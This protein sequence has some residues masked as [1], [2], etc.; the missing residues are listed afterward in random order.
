M[1]LDVFKEL[2]YSHSVLGKIKDYLYQVYD[3]YKRHLDVVETTGS[4]YTGARRGESDFNQTNH[5]AR[6][7]R[8]SFLC[9]DRSGRSDE[10]K[11]YLSEEREHGDEDVGTFY[12]SRKRAFPVLYL[13]A[14]DFL[15]T[16]AMSAPCESL[17]SR[18]ND[19]VTKKRNRLSSNTIKNLAV[20]KSLGVIL[21]E[22]E[23]IF[24]EEDEVVEVGE[25]EGTTDRL[26]V[27]ESVGQS[28]HDCNDDDDDLWGILGTV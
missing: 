17:F 7:M 25:G 23:T 4:N 10:I 6:S 11:A 3:E 28:D 16:P 5:E 19:V 22:A 26:Q 1:K 20:L 27:I 9:R 21:D 8:E 12:E 14:R 2:G 18:L 15:A 24:D 13:M